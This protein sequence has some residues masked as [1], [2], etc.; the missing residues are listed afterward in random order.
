MVWSDEGNTAASLQCCIILYKK[1]S[2]WVSIESPC[3]CTF[4]L[5]FQENCYSSHLHTFSL[6]AID[7]SLYTTAVLRSTYTCSALRSIFYSNLIMK[8]SQ[9]HYQNCFLTVQTH[10][11]KSCSGGC[12]VG[13]ALLPGTASSPADCATCVWF[14]RQPSLPQTP[15]TTPAQPAQ[16]GC[17]GP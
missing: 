17:M 2:I 1:L 14:H 4:S 13:Q 3:V 12:A 8:L 5:W 16:A 9:V 10:K 7:S 15:P 6:R 11:S